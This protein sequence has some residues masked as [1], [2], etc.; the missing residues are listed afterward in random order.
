M[1][2]LFDHIDNTSNETTM[3]WLQA[4][5]EKMQSKMDNY[6]GFTQDK[7]A[8]IGPV[9]DPR[10]KLTL[11]PK[12]LQSR[13]DYQKQLI[14]ELGLR[15]VTS[16][17][18]EIDDDD[19]FVEPPLRK[20]RLD[21]SFDEELSSYPAENVKSQSSDPL[22]YWKLNEARFIHLASL[23]RDV[24]SIQ[25]SSVPCEQVFSSAGRTVSEHRASLNDE[26][27]EAIV[28]L[29]TWTRFLE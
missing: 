1:S 8:Y 26:S 2:K 16:S 19:L 24:L 18:V 15:N 27:V 10:I 25:A 17:I 21:T 12:K 13:Q 22:I 6:I 5:C 7:V 20:P 9:L 3:S 28:G 4:L 11:M 29:K 23:A 14:F